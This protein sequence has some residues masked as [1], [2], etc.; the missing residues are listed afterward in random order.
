[1]PIEA[2]V[3]I[4]ARVFR[5][6][7]SVLEMGRDLAK[8]NEFVVFLIRRVVNP[9]LQAALNMNRGCGW[10]DPACGHQT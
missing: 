2:M 5:G 4:E 7:D 1:M 10:I 9:G 3:L 6:D 8:G